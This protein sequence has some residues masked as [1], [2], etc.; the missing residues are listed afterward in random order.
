MRF[1][2]QC[3]NFIG[4]PLS[5]VA[6]RALMILIGWVSTLRKRAGMEPDADSA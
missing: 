1:G 5:S 3:G 4:R 6:F 2:P